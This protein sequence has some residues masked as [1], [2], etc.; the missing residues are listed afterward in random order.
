[1]D[2]VGAASRSYVYVRGLN[3]SASLSSDWSSRG[4]SVS[5]RWSGRFNRYH[6]TSSNY[7]NYSATNMEYG[8]E[9][10]FALPA[11]FRVSTNFTYYTRRGYVDESLNTN[12]A[13]WN[14]TASWHWKKANL[15]FLVDG[16]DL[17]GQIKTVSYYVEPWDAPKSGATRCRATP[18]SASA[19][20]STFP[21]SDPPRCA[22]AKKTGG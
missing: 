20:T 4:H 8:A 2:A 14:V 22:K 10:T 12:E 6:G 3:P 19:T 18:C 16:Y 13:I 1:M 5:L 11:N 21:R 9:A 15:T 7:L 17:L